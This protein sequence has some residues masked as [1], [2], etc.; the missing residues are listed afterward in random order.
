[1]THDTRLTRRQI[2]AAATVAALPGRLAFAAPATRPGGAGTWSPV[3]LISAEIR[4]EFADRDRPDLGGEGGQWIRSLA[5][6]P[7]G[8]TAVWGTDVGGLYRSLDAGLTWEPCNVGFTPRGCCCVAFDPRDANRILVVA[9]NSMAI[10]EHGLYLSTD[11]GGSWRHVLAA[12]YASAHDFRHQA[13]FEPDGDRCYWSRVADDTANYGEPVNDPALYRSDDRG[14]TWQRLP[15]SDRLG[16]GFVVCTPGRLFVATPAGLFRSADGGESFEH[17]DS[18]D[19]TGLTASGDRL[20]AT[21]QGAVLRS[22]DGGGT[23]RETSADLAEAGYTLRFAQASP[24]DPDR[25]GVFKQHDD[26]WDWSR[27]VSHDGGATWTRS[28]IDHELAFLPQNVRQPRFAWHPT[29]PAI[30]LASGGD[31]PTKSADGGRTFAWSGAGVNNVLVGGLFHFAEA[32]PDTLFVGSQ[33]YNGGVTRDGGRTWDYVNPS[34]NEWGGFTYGGYSPDGRVLWVGVAASWGGGRQLTISRDGG[35]TWAEVEGVAWADSPGKRGPYGINTGFSRGDA[36][37]AGPFRSADGGATWAV[38]D[39]CSGVLGGAGG[40][41]VGGHL[42]DDGGHASLAVSTD[43]GESWKNVPVPGRVQDASYDPATDVA[44]VANEDRL[45][46]VSGATG[47]APRVEAIDTPADSLGNRRVT[48]V[49]HDPRDRR[50]VYAAQHKNVYATDVAAMRST[51][52]GRTWAVLTRRDPL[53]ADRRD[54]AELDGGREAMQVRVHPTTG[55]A[56]FSTGCYGVWKWSPQG[57]ENGLA[58]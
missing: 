30:A 25:L 54:P 51:D 23:W 29:D 6:G 43:G 48:G 33:D 19:Y 15:D 22:D 50:I 32:D 21:T 5:L 42:S 24:A 3:P 53:P 37:F 39:G 16:G 52:G 35:G 58:R 46:R 8:R 38:M 41:L 27:H 14:E 45:L 7:D 31:W 20:Y 11:R 40:V 2:L 17:L 57:R 34:G 36:W 12:K 44:L 56:W 9:A 47:D 28:E 49:C 26:G 4:R 13:A 1:M 10:P 18:R 55:E